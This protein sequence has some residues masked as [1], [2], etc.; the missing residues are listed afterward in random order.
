MMR[1]LL[2]GW[3]T[4]AEVHGDPPEARLL[5]EEEPTVALAGT[6]RRREYTT[7]RHCA[8]TALR[9][10]GVPY[11]PLVPGERGAP[12]WPEGVVGSMTH[13]PGYRAA[14]TAHGRDLAALGIDA[15]PAKPLWTGMLPV[16][17]L[18]TEQ[19]RLL[20]LGAAYPD[21]PWDRLLF[22]A[23]EAVYKAW[24]P[25]TRRFLDFSMADITFDAEHREFEAGLL[26]PGPRVGGV[27]VRSFSGRWAA[28][29]DLLIT[30][31]FVPQFD[32]AISRTSPDREL[33]PNFP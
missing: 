18:P 5:P 21:V 4:V 33:T 7:V 11:E 17:S 29:D 27:E 2:P 16:I 31:A 22:S 15:E 13:C 26:T 32:R 1:K 14:A 8:R 19:R 28:D 12:R 9:E 6:S 25:L 20:A 3:V 10:L 23:K 30:A 24:F